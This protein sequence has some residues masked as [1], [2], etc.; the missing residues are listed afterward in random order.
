MWVTPHETEVTSLNF[1][2][3]LLLYGLTKLRS[4]GNVPQSHA[5]LYYSQRTFKGGLLITED[6]EIL[7]T[8]HV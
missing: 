4:Y 1:P 6:T 2:F 5:I 7:N 8:A 3:P